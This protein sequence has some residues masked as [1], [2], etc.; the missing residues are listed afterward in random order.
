MTPQRGFW[1]ALALA[2]SMGFALRTSMPALVNP[3]MVHDD[4]RQ[5]VF[6]VPRLHDA[7]LFA[8]D[9]IADYYQAQAPLGYQ[10]V[11]WAATLLTDAITVSKLLPLVLTVVLVLAGFW[12]GMALWQRPDAAALGTALLLWSAWQYDDVA[13]AT[14]R[15]YALPLLTLQLAALAAGRW[16]FALAVLPL[17]ALLYP[18]GCALA[19]VTMG[20]WSAWQH[21]FRDWRREWP[22]RRLPRALVRAWLSLGAVTVVALGLAVLGQFG[23]ASYGPTV[24]GAEARQMPE[25]QQ[26]GR[27]AYFV[28]APYKFWLESSRSGFALGPKDRLLGDLPVLVTPFLLAVT[29]AAWMLAGRRGWTRPPPV[30]PSGMLLLI[31]LVASLTLFFAAHVLLYLLYLPARHVQFSLPLVWAMSSGLVW[32][33]A[34]ERLAARFG[35]LAKLA[36]RLGLSGGEAFALL[37]TALL[38]LH[39]PPPGDFYVTGRHPAIYA[40]LRATPPDTLIGALPSDSSILPL[41]GQRGV[42]ASYE[43]LLPYQPGYY[44][45]LRERLEAFRSAYYA[46]TLTP[47]AEVVQHYGVNLV[48]VDADVLERRRR[49][50]REHPPALEKVLNRCGVLRERELVVVTAACILEAAEEPSLGS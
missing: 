48:I 3:L 47:M 46:P 27:A 37:G 22:G 10:A 40:Y 38:A 33:L 21:L 7:R 45:P 17:Q 30:P 19:V 1:L 6:W 5:H 35:S 36:A 23:A 12:L 44:E 2:V 34:G 43:H 4:V 25:F 29:L 42:L 20:G 32:V 50:E 41:F 18:L 13:S 8:G 14:P 9:W 31:V 39:P 28:P 15:A 24:S 16:N 11:Y 49:S 26:G